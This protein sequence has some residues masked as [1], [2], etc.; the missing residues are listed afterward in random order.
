MGRA[1]LPPERGLSVER[2]SGLVAGEGGPEDG[3]PPASAAIASAVGRSGLALWL[4]RI[5]CCL[6]SRFILAFGCCY[7]FLIST[8][9]IE[10]KAL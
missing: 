5:G 7:L 8:L 2:P 4:D 1:G 6:F 9:V 3:W 10:K